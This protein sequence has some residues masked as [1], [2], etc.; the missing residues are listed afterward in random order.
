MTLLDILSDYFLIILF[1][2][3]LICGFIA[4]APVGP[5]NLWTAHWLLSRGRKTVI[6]FLA[7]VIL[8]DLIYVFLGFWSYFFLS[9]DSVFQGGKG[10][11]IAGGIFIMLVGFYSLAKNQKKATQPQPD[12]PSAL[13]PWKAFLT[14]ALLCASNSMLFIMWFFIAGVYDSYA[15]A[16]DHVLSLSAVLLGVL[17]GDLL[18]FGAFVRLLEKGL[19]RLRPINL[20]RLQ[21]L[22][23]I[24]LVLFGLFTACR[25][26]GG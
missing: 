3:S 22:I 20:N 21:N 14:G 2:T 10:W 17:V 6:W 26:I 15:L 8:V 23:A 19:T 18:W 5:V 16:A 12:H 11:E 4:S 7:G 13:Q 9:L 1:S 24:S 25:Q